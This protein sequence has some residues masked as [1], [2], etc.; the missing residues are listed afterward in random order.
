MKNPKVLDDFYVKFK[1]FETLDASKNISPEN[2]NFEFLTWINQLKDQLYENNFELAQTLIS[3]I[4]ET[5]YLEFEY[6]WNYLQSKLKK[7]QKHMDFTDQVNA[8]QSAYYD[9]QTMFTFVFSLLNRLTMLHYIE[10]NIDYFYN[11]IEEELEKDATANISKIIRNKLKRVTF[12]NWRYNPF[13]TQYE[14][15]FLWS[16]FL[17]EA[18]NVDEHYGVLFKIEDP[19]AFENTTFNF[20]TEIILSIYLFLFYLKV[21]LDEYAGHKHKGSFF[22]K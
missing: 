3:Q 5:P 4:K 10:S 14:N 13:I 22:I 12:N 9:L 8:T 18:R 15:A 20:F 19:E 11:L 17:K 6:S 2:T 7:H 1:T 21:Y 16:E